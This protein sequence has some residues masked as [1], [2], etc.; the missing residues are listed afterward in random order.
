[1][2][3][4]FHVGLWSFLEILDMKL[5]YESYCY[6]E[7]HKGFTEFHKEVYYKNFEAL[8]DFFVKL[9]V[10]T[11]LPFWLIIQTNVLL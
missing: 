5:L 7:F 9:C 2:V 8:C 1:M 4:E 11:I 3:S 6:T 10:I